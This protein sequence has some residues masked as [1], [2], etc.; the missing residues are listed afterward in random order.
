MAE[1]YKRRLQIDQGLDRAP[2]L[3]WLDTKEGRR[4]AQARL[5]GHEVHI[6]EHVAGDGQP[7][8]IA[9]EDNVAARVPGRMHDAKTRDLI[10]FTQYAGH[11]IGPSRPQAD[12]QAKEAV[13][14]LHGFAAFHDWHIRFMAGEWDVEF[15]TEDLGRTLMIGMTMGQ[16]DHA[17]RVPAH[18]TEDPAPGP[19]RRGINQHVFRKVNVEQMW[20]KA[21]K[22]P[23]TFGDLVHDES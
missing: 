20:R 13:V 22:L 23:D 11:G 5:A 15:F 1:A 14:R 2:V 10:A 16:G 19:A 9:E 17:Q 6:G 7:V 18:L 3:A 4:L 8:G 21:G 12:A